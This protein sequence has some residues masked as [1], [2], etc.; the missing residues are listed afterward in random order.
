MKPIAVVA[1]GGNSLTQPG[2][3]GTFAEQQRHART[4]CEGIADVLASGYRVV[5][6]HGN[7]PQVGEALLRTELA[8]PELPALRLDE[9]DAETQGAIGYLLQQTLAEVLAARGHKLAVVSL[10]TQVRVD[11]DDPAFRNPAKPIGP[12]YRAEEALDRKNRLGWTMIE[13]AGRGWRRVVPSPRPLEIVEL[14]AIRACLDAGV[15]AIA[16]GGGGIPVIRRDGRLEGVEA[17]I[18]KDRASALLARSLRAHLLL[19]STAV[20]RVAW[21][22]GQ[23]DQRDLDRMSWE[24]A[25]TYLAQGEFPE[26]SMG[27]KIES[28]LEFLQHG[29]RRVVIASPETIGA[30]LR[31]Q[32][33]TEILPPRK[34]AGSLRP[35][36]A[37]GRGRAVA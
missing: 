8:M 11:P 25:R 33:G 19:F 23:P 30:A 27:P 1:I 15:V 32:A 5:V 14:D 22:F 12:F 37:T 36:K 21:H 26:G 7:G 35:R 17:V 4:T 6:T 34:S 28:A 20:E 24:E 31:R 10:V 3:R 9:C 29:G 18:D 2:E 16:A 13:D